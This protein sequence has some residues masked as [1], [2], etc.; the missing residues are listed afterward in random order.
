M[1]HE[2]IFCWVR[3]CRLWF[4]VGLGCL[5]TVETV[6]AQSGS[7]NGAATVTI[8]GNVT[9]GNVTAGYTY[10]SS[11]SVALS[12]NGLATSI[13]GLAYEVN[14][15]YNT[16][17]GLQS[18]YTT[19]ASNVQYAVAQSVS[20]LQQINTDFTSLKAAMGSN[21][22]ATVAN[23]AA[24]AS[25]GGFSGMISNGIV[26]AATTSANILN[27]GISPKLDAIK[28]VLLTNGLGSNVVNV[29]STN[30]DITMTNVINVTIPSMDAL[31]RF[32]QD[33]AS[34][35]DT[36]SAYQNAFPSN[37]ETLRAA[38]EGMS[39][40]SGLTMP[41]APQMT[42]DT[43]ADEDFMKFEIPRPGG[44]SWVIRANPHYHFGPQID[45]F[46]T[47]FEWVCTF[48]F[49]LAVGKILSD[50]VNGY[51]AAHQTAMPNITIL[52]NNVGVLVGIGYVVLFTLAAGAFAYVISQ[53]I[54]QGLFTNLSANPFAGF[55]S[56]AMYL[57]NMF[58]PVALIVTQAVLLVTT[59]W[60]TSAAVFVFGSILRLMA[61]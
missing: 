22:V 1:H 5:S 38:A 47:G 14:Q 26:A 51:V 19:A 2:R 20:S 43:Y 34:G 52:G 45:A 46:R 15:F 7:S 48:A 21:T 41:T 56:Q 53:R 60:L 24:L 57:L 32:A 61:A 39:P 50:A 18:G 31:N 29:S 10:I 54:D 44:G 36:V 59:R 30:G 55:G 37:Y 3:L 23:T 58:F 33:S 11:A 25:L 28:D 40:F 12:V 8:T 35:K 27:T 4:W 6:R 16:L 49:L 9:G 13:D 17:L 42:F